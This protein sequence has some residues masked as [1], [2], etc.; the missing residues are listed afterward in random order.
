MFWKGPTCD[1]TGDF[2]C[3]DPKRF[4]FGCFGMVPNVTQI[5]EGPKRHEGGK[6][7]R[8]EKNSVCSE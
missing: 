4:T 7:N 5:R 3:G 6:E 1:F 2:I 8:T